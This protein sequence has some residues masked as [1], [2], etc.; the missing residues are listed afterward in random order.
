MCCVNVCKVINCLYEVCLQYRIESL[1]YPS[2]LLISP[3]IKNPALWAA[4]MF[5]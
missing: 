4:L 5:N 1:C 2:L 3:F